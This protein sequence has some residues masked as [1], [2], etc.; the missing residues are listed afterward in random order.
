MN[1]YPLTGQDVALVLGGLCGA[2]ITGWGAYK[3]GNVAAMKNV[4]D[5]CAANVP[6]NSTPAQKVAKQKACDAAYPVPSP[7]MGKIAMYG[8]VG[9]IVFIFAFVLYAVLGWGSVGSSM[10]RAQYQGGG[11]YQSFQ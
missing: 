7:L 8:G 3:T 10:A 9:F 5:T 2:V 11:I 1:Q 6:K 4:N